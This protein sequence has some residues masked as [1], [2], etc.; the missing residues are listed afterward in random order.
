MLKLF[1]IILLCL[2]TQAFAASGSGNVSSVINGGYA[3]SVSAT[4]P[5]ITLPSGGSAGRIMLVGGNSSLSTNFFYGF[6]KQKGSTGMY[7]VPAGVTTTCVNMKVNTGNITHGVF[8]YATGAFTDNSATVPAGAQCFGIDCT[9]N[10]SWVFLGGADVSIRNSEPVN[11]TWTAGQ[12]PFI[13]VG[14]NSGT[15]SIWVLDCLEQ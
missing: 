9:A 6:A 7:Q 11:F 15:K 10:N 14:T 4:L 12:V 3:P 8:G 5:A 13:K 1:S 2:S